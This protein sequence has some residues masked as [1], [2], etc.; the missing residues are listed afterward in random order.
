[1][2]CQIF[3]GSVSTRRLTAASRATTVVAVEDWVGIV[4]CSQSF[5]QDSGTM[6]STIA[7]VKKSAFVLVRPSP[8]RRNAVV[9]SI[10]RHDGHA[11]AESCRLVHC[12]RLRTSMQTLEMT[13]HIQPVDATRK[14]TV[15]Y[16][17]MP[18]SGID[19]PTT[20]S[21]HTYRK[22]PFQ[23]SGRKTPKP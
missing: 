12:Q 3:I 10:C 23:S 1:M 14:A 22:R 15:P 9:A 2:T 7:P 11:V 21:N 5:G 19:K 13:Y 16:G 8:I 6:H 18:L 20:R 4:G 17:T